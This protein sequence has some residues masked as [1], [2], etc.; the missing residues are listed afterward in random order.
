MENSEYLLEMRKISKSFGGINALKSVNFNVRKGEIHALIGENGAGKSTLFAQLF[1]ESQINV[2][3][4]KR[5]L[6]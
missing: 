3:L 2:T 5:P 1:W 6:K 4:E